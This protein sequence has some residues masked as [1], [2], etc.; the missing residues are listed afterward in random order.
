MGFVMT[1]MPIISSAHLRVPASFTHGNGCNCTAE[2]DLRLLKKRLGHDLRAPLRALKT[3]PQWIR[4]DLEATT[5]VT[6]STEKYLSMTEASAERLDQFMIGLLSFLNVGTTGDQP[7]TVDAPLEI[8]KIFA[9]HGVTSKNRIN[10]SDEL[11][12][13]TCIKSEL[14]TLV[15]CIVLNAVRHC[16]E[17]PLVLEVFGTI[18]NHQVNIVFSDNGP[19]ID[20]KHH[21]RIFEPFETLKP[22]DQVEGSGLGLAIAAKVLRSWGGEIGVESALGEGSKFS[23]NFPAF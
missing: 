18:Q 6:A 10:L 16:T 9:A 19:G 22:R 21:A 23:V 15:D 3:I 14:R 13:F 2:Q 11:H 12:Q 8:S 20:P 7:K 17:S 1:E 4:E 5:D